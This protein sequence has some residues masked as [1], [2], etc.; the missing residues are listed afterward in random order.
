MLVVTKQNQNKPHFII[1]YTA[2]Q[3]VTD[4]KSLSHHPIHSKKIYSTK[5][6]METQRGTEKNANI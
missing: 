3:I 5:G 4:G 2:L 1:E 6:T